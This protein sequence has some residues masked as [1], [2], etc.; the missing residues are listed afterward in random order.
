MIVD[1][2]RRAKNVK[3]YLDDYELRTED[4]LMVWEVWVWWD[5]S[6]GEL[7]W[8]VSALSDLFEIYWKL[9]CD[10]GRSAYG[11]GWCLIIQKL[12]HVVWSLW[13][14]IFIFCF[15]SE[16][17]FSWRGYRGWDDRGQICWK[18]HIIR[19]NIF[20]FDIKSFFIVLL[21]NL[22]CVIK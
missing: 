9:T 2:L 6:S 14:G 10:V 11:D 1:N 12:E 16:S 7:L 19:F 15:L 22:W 5:I 18:L 20:T 21:S 4:W 17:L 13:R 3:K 8:A